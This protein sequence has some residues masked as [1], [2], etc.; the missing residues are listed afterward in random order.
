MK[1]NIILLSIVFVVL[2][3]STSCKKNYQCTC[4]STYA[5]GNYTFFVDAKSTKK[6]AQVWCSAFASSN[7][8]PGINT[9]CILN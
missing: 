6:D 7:A 1:K 3:S 5:G 2:L 4:T 9:I 8:Q